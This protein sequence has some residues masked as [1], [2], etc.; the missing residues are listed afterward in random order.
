M[1]NLHRPLLAVATSILLS[2]CGASPRPST[3]TTRDLAALDSVTSSISGIPVSTK[4]A[5]ARNH[6]LQG[7]RGLMGEVLEDRAERPAREPDGN[8]PTRR[9]R[10][11]T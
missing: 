10:S 3:T 5:D 4:S 11:P 8:R 1:S 6:F 2:A 9:L 7:Q